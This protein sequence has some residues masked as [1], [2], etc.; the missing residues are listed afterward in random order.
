MC[1][2]V[3]FILRTAQQPVGPERSCDVLSQTINRGPLTG[4]SSRSAMRPPEKI[5]ELL[6]SS[7]DL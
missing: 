6:D 7:R 1:P 4:I 2:A 3:V 5:A